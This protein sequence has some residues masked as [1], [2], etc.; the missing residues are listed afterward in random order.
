MLSAYPESSFTQARGENCVYRIDLHD[1]S[2]GRDA[3]YVIRIIEG[4]TDFQVITYWG[5]HGASL[6]S[7]LLTLV[8]KANYRSS[9]DAL[10]AAYEQA[11]KTAAT[12]KAKGYGLIFMNT[13]QQPNTFTAKASTSTLQTRVLPTGV[14]HIPLLKNFD[15]PKPFKKMMDESHIFEVVNVR[16]DWVFIYIMDKQWHVYDIYKKHIKTLDHKVGSHMALQRHNG[17]VFLGYLKG[18]GHVAIFDIVDGLNVQPSIIDVATKPWTVRRVM[19]TEI[20]MD[21]YSRRSSYDERLEVHLNEYTL[22]SI[23]KQLLWDT[24]DIH[25][26]NLLIR[27]VNSTYASS[28]LVKT[29]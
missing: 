17:Y 18:D 29:S 24:H 7:K 23:D 15:D 5:R 8:Y 4:L 27:P 28:I 16:T 11:A 20:F 22:D 1:T 14:T 2:N 19:L 9:S 6:Q 13:V 3:V 26:E 12:K 25:K 21:I 10:S